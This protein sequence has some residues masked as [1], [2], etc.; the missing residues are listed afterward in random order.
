MKRY[1]IT[2]K[3]T[4]Q[5]VSQ[6]HYLDYLDSLSDL[7]TVM[8]VVFETTRGLHVHYVLETEYELSS[9]DSRLYKTKFGWNHLSVPVW[10][11]KGWTRYCRK[12]YENNL[13]L[14]SIIKY[15]ELDFKVDMSTPIK[16]PNKKMF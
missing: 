5:P 1:A 2:T 8:N 11:A 12:D 4:R 10:H 15:S 6:Q 16:N 9:K 13:D 3:K 14:N 7:G